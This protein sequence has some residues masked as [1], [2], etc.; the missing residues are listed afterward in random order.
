VALSERNSLLAPEDDLD[1]LVIRDAATGQLRLTSMGRKAYAPACEYLGISP[2]SVTT[3]Q[4][5][6]EARKV[7]AR[8]LISELAGKLRHK[9]W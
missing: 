7:A 3:D 8:L 4:T 2:G 5:L 6:L 1:V 9:E